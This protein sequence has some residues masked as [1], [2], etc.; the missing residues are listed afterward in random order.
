MSRQI[1]RNAVILFLVL[2]W[3][4]NGFSNQIPAQASLLPGFTI[5][6]TL[7]WHNFLSGPSAWELEDYHRYF[8]QAKRLGLNYVAFHCY[9]GGAQRYAPYVE[10]LVRVQYRNV[11]PE[12]GFDTSL[13]ARWGYRPLPLSG[14]AFHTAEKFPRI[15]EVDAFGASYA[16]LARDN[17]DRYDRA[18]RMFLEVIRLAHQHQIKVALGFE[19]GIHPPELASIVPQDSM[20]PGAD[21]PDP[22]HP[23]SLEILRNTLDDI[24]DSYPQ[25]DG[26]WLWLHEHS[27]L[28]Q[29]AQPGKPFQK[30][31]EE[32]A[33]LFQ[34]NGNEETVFAGVWSLAY[35]QA[36]QKYLAVKAPSLEITIS[37]WGGGRQLPELLQGLDQALGKGIIFSC[38]NAGLGQSAQ[39]LTLGEIA[40]HRRVW[41][42]PWLEGDHALWHLQP[43]VQLL[44]EQI[45]LAHSQQ[46]DGVLAIHWRTEEIK[47]NLSAFA[48]FAGNPSAIPPLKAFYRQAVE[49]EYGSDAAN[50][51]TDLLVRMDEQKTLEL[52]SPEYFPYQ[53]SWGRISTARREE[54][55]S[56]YSS[57]QHLASNERN[58]VFRANL[59]WLAARLLFT[60]LLDETGRKLEPAYQLKEQ[61][62]SDQLG[63]DALPDKRRIAKTAL[64]EAPLEKLFT[65]FAQHVRSRGELGQLSSMN[66][67]LWLQYLELKQF[68]AGLEGRAPNRK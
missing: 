67:R 14:F 5:R 28:V 26:I 57:V 30:L 8:E 64:E 29:K 65:T 42:I 58:A 27:L 54:I 37:G 1:P 61:W 56:F 19:F 25:L 49:K 20:I 41:A 7:L 36:A 33:H 52:E 32:N 48:Q 66:Q 39:S 63:P 68:L 10:P 17:R 18:H 51:L 4:C 12:A 16:L 59:E 2:F 23:A 11:L 9:T 22:T 55:S 50:L 35:L 15:G 60:L 6:G 46:L 45:R 13:T 53:P 31:M 43:R 47:T 38:L 44:Q 34:H 62:M 3:A 40:R 21:L 24:V